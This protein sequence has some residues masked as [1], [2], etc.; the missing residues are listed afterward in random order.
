MGATDCIE[1][2][3][4]RTDPAEVLPDTDLV[5]YIGERRASDGGNVVVISDSYVTKLHPQ[6]EIEDVKQAVAKAEELGI[7]TPQIRRIVLG[8]RYAEC[9]QERIHGPTLMEAWTSLGWLSTV[10]VAFQLRWMVRRM[11]TATSP[12]AGSL[13]TGLCRSFWI[14][15]VYEVPARASESVIT[16]ILN[17]WYNLVSF[18][19]EAGK[20]P[21][22]H[23]KTCEQGPFHPETGGL[24]FTHNDLALRNMILEDSTRD[25]WVVDWDLSGWYPRCFEPA[26][27][28]NFIIPEEWGRFDLF[29][30]EL[31][32]WIATGSYRREE[33]MLAEVQHKANR[34]PAAR[35]FNIM[36]GVTPSL[37]PVED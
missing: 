6:D 30:W 12:T 20:S 23:R 14:E 3:E 24:V 34:F 21:E 19:R 27:M 29:R 5:E 25:L 28:G 9:I 31:F 10:R 7:R 16:S 36:A 18:R 8:P 26:G 1:S 32:V 2:F 15:D 33:R 35:R 17:F 4:E 37:R 11:R 13:G 22:D